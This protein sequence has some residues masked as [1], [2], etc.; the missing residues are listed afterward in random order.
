MTDD[1]S[2][3]GNS[4]MMVRHKVVFVGDVSVGKTSVMNRFI[5]NKFKDTYDV[6]YFQIISQQ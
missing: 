5:E 4:I 1:F 3:G 2:E 6:C